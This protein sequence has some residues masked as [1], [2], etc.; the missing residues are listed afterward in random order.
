MSLS[1]FGSASPDSQMIA[2]TILASAIVSGRW[3]SADTRRMASLRFSCHRHCDH[4]GPALATRTPRAAPRDE[5]MA[6]ESVETQVA[7]LALTLVVIVLWIVLLLLWLMPPTTPPGSNVADQFRII[8]T[9]P[10][11]LPLALLVVSLTTGSICG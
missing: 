9:K 5:R 7:P 10:W 11:S 4:D 3:M 6:A 1:A 8:V 2:L